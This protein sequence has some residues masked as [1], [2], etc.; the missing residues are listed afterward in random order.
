[1]RRA[2]L[3]AFILTCWVGSLSWLAWR[4]WGPGSTDQFE[5]LDQRLPPGDAYLALRIGDDQVGIVSSV[6]DTVRGGARTVE[7]LDL[8]ARGSDT[9][10]RRTLSAEGVF[11][12]PLSLHEL[13]VVRG[14]DGTRLRLAATRDSVG[15]YSA[16]VA[17]GGDTGS[18]TWPTPRRGAVRTVAAALRYLGLTNNPSAAGPVMLLDPLGLD[19]Q[20]FEGRV[21]AES[22]LVVPDSARLDAGS[23]RWVAAR[24]DTVRA[25]RIEYTAYG[26]PF[27]AWVDEDGNLVRASTPLGATVE[28]TAFEIVRAGYDPRPAPDPSAPRLMAGPVPGARVTRLVV[29]LGGADT[30]TTA[31]R[32]IE[33]DAPNQVRRGDTLEIRASSLPPAPV[34]PTVGIDDI[35]LMQASAA[36]PSADPRLL[37]Q[38]RRIAEPGTDPAL[39]ATAL[40]NWVVANVEL[41]RGGAD[42]ALGALEHRRATMAGRTLLFLALARA[43]QLPARPV[44]GLRWD[45]TAFHYHGWAEVKLPGGWVAAD[46]ALDQFPAD[47]SRLRLATGVGADPATL[48]I[49]FGR[50]RP[51]VI[52][53]EAGTR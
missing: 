22:V 53:I 43:V 36:V 28:R 3:A 37:A 52:D 31:W 33:L 18:W 12:P 32:R 42:H 49:L 27:D 16:R 15:R 41:D 20:P 8:L 46:P 1:M 14:G 25:R 6:L 7:R 17:I 30:T 48:A 5:G 10:W 9:A 51:R 2:S 47:A 29:T 40:S 35:A 24:W 21:V 4:E 39:M 44:A 13:S 34:D 45:G 26:L 23:G 38:A 19:W 50:L 11:G